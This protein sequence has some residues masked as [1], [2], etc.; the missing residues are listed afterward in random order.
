MGD[1]FSFAQIPLTASSMLA[2]MGL[3]RAQAGCFDLATA[4]FSPGQV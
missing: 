1:D 4:R 3:P 2:N